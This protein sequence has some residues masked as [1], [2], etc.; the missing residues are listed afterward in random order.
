VLKVAQQA[1]STTGRKKHRQT[2]RQINR[3]T[4]TR[5]AERQT[6]DRQTGRLVLAF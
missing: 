6:K 3:K 1:G 5:Q 4:D 2:G